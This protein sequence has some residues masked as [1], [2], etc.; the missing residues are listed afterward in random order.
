M[1]A[2]FWWFMLPWSL[3]QVCAPLVG[4]HL[5]A[6]LVHIYT[7]PLPDTNSSM[8]GSHASKMSL[9]FGFV[10]FTLQECN[11]SLLYHA[12]HKLLAL[13]L[14]TWY[15]R[16]CKVS[17]SGH[18]W[19]C[20]ECVGGA[21]EVQM[22]GGVCMASTVW[23]EWDG[24]NVGQRQEFNVYIQFNCATVHTREGQAGLQSISQGRQSIWANNLKHVPNTIHV[25][26]EVD[27]NYGY[28]PFKTQFL[29]NLDSIVDGR[30]M[31][32]GSL[33]LQPKFMGLPRFGGF[34]C[35]T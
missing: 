19:S 7:M 20:E 24:K 3:Q 12:W 22:W 27:Q 17:V 1:A 18:A 34:D 5:M 29:S 10:W 33:C 23:T 8:L 31:A 14:L 9:Y 35:E 32:K 2:K 15:S 30:L 4:A 25:T 13:G 11:I 21:W 16:G 6:A 28:G 26:Q